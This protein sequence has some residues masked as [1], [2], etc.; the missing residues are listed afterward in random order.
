MKKL[1]FALVAAGAAAVMGDAIESQ[2]IVGYQNKAVTGGNYNYMVATFDKVNPLATYT[3]AD[4]SVNDEFCYSTLS[5]LDTDSSTKSFVIDGLT[6]DAFTYYFEADLEGTEFEGQPGWYY[7]DDE[8]ELHSANHIS[9]PFGSAFYIEGLDEGEAALV[10]SGVV[11]D[12]DT[13]IDVVGGAY[14]YMGNCSPANL[15]L[16]DI[17]VNEDFIY[18]T[19]SFLDSDSSTKSFVIGGLSADAFTYYFEADL[20]GTEFEGQP[21]W[22]YVDDESEIHSANHI[23]VNAGDMFYIEG[24]DEGDAQVI[25]PS[26]L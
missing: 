25:V 15:T 21:G 24:L 18:S 1:M 6:A 8:S 10:F 23:T 12:G 5:F 9:V 3:L 7:V 19:L 22:Y 17:G 11:V 16:A 14:N 2:N 13:P 26:A 20:E 4:I